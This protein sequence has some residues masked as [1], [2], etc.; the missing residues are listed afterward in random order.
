MN[1]LI[2]C[3]LYRLTYTFYSHKNIYLFMCK[4][5]EGKLNRHTHCPELLPPESLIS[6]GLEI[7]INLKFGTN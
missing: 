5:S 2:K 7:I 4:R 6:N 1:P 3:I